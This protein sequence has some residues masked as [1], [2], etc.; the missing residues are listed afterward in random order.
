MYIFG[1]SYN[2]S[3]NDSK[4]D[5]EKEPEKDPDFERA[6]ITFKENILPVLVENIRIICLHL[7]RCLLIAEGQTTDEILELEERLSKADNI[8]LAKLPPVN[9]Q[10]QK[11]ESQIT[12]VKDLLQKTKDVK[13]ELKVEILTADEEID[14]YLQKIGTLVSKAGDNYDAKVKLMAAQT[15]N[16][17]ISKMNQLQEF[18]KQ[19]FDGVK[20]NEIF[21]Q[22]ETMMD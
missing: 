17:S 4:S 20:A 19:T 14:E 3:N 8:D 22:V 1:K 18:E 9:E 7:R 21:K 15:E 5:Q 2:V 11:M 10:L 13:Q 12:Q 6:K 16:L